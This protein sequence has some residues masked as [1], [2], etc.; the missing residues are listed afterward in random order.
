MSNFVVFLVYVNFNY[1]F[2]LKIKK[3]RSIA[4]E[5]FKEKLLLE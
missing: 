1:F 3:K 4:L 5:I 2:A